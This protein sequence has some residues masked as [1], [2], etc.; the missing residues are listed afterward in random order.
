MQG[1]WVGPVLYVLYPLQHPA[2]WPAYGK[3]FINLVRI[4]YDKI[5]EKRRYKREELGW[6]KNRVKKKT[7][8]SC[9]V[10]GGLFVFKDEKKFFPI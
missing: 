5:G 2:H 3:Q 10:S 8:L 7:R 4:G 9:S 6:R 1:P